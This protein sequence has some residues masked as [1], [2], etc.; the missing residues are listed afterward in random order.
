M[1]TR[2]LW[3]LLCETFR[4]YANTAGKARP[5]APEQ[6]LEKIDVHCKEDEDPEEGRADAQDARIRWRRPSA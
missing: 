3:T 2:N 5:T 4:R 6:V 1:N